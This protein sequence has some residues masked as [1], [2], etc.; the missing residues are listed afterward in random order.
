MTNKTSN[1]I[2]E[3][4]ADMNPVYQYLYQAQK[5]LLS[6][7]RDA[8]FCYLLISSHNISSQP[9]TIPNLLSDIGYELHVLE[10][11]LSIARS[12]K[13]CASIDYEIAQ[14]KLKGIA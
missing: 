13:R 7:Y 10:C 3:L 6:K 4:Q 14:E 5:D 8:S 2:I 9:S 11:K 1:I 12:K